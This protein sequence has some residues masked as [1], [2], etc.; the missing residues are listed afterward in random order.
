MRPILVAVTTVGI[1][2][3]RIGRPLRELRKS[4]C[5]V[6]TETAADRV[7]GVEADSVRRAPAHRKPETSIVL[8]TD[9]RVEI[10][11]ADERGGRRVFIGQRE[12]TA[13]IDVGRRAAHG[14]CDAV[15]RARPRAE[16]LRRVELDLHPESIRVA[17]QVACGHAPLDADLPLDGHVPR[18][19]P[20]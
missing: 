16:E 12:P 7:V 14:K 10:E 4:A 6:V 13:L 18:L 15:Y 8:F 20:R 1:R 19:D 9:A 2:V 5:R 17:A 11:I 3:V